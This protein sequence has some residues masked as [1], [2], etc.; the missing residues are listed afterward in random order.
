MVGSVVKNWRRSY[1]ARQFSIIAVL[2]LL[3]LYSIGRIVD[4]SLLD[5]RQDYS[6]YI[7][8]ALAIV[9]A[10]VGGAFVIFG[11]GETVRPMRLF[12]PYYIFAVVPFFV[13]LT[14]REYFGVF[15]VNAIL[16]HLSAGVEGSKLDPALLQAIVLFS[17]A[18]F[19]ICAAIHVLGTHALKLQ[20][21]VNALAVPMLLLNPLTIEGVYSLTFPATDLSP[22]G[23]FFTPVQ[24][25]R[26]A[27]SS[28]P[29]IIHIY[30]ESTEATFA[31][32]NETR[33]AMEPLERLRGRGF[34]AT[35]I[36]Q[37]EATAWTVAGQ[38]ASQCGVPLI[39]PWA[40]RVGAAPRAA[41][42]MP[43]AT[44][45]SD[46]LARDGYRTEFLKGFSL[47]FAGTDAFLRSHNYKSGVGLSDHPGFSGPVSDWGAY[48]DETFDFAFKRI[49]QL[50]DAEAP[51]YFSVL[52]NGA[53]FPGG[54]LSP[55]C[56]DNAKESPAFPSFAGAIGCTNR[57]TEQFVRKLEQAKLLEN[58]IVIVQSD[59]LI[60]RNPLDAA[61]SE[62]RRS[63]F[64][65]AF[66]PG[67]PQMTTDQEASM[68]DVYPTILELIGYDIPENRAALGVSLLSGKPTLIEKLGAD[69]LDH[70]IGGGTDLAKALWPEKTTAAA[71]GSD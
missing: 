35:S 56:A 49:G 32:L 8:C 27:D 4:N 59:H 34:S 14:V 37:V 22:G 29:N 20:T 33:I 58:T 15:D 57:L 25:D 11:Q 67:V 66:G 51:F 64:F 48:D 53:H 44:C 13:W 3:F 55:A 42:F 30:L 46:L 52:T 19:C 16:Y 23:P 61:L 6:I 9:T 70:S 63:N 47:S 41:H 50:H 38:V 18:C 5:G 26:T 43:G 31:K 1:A 12:R 71:R 28:R 69:E 68:L 24:A 45:L 36:A 65:T 54:L 62:H 7:K 21:I 10:L 39:F 17:V 2:C 60:M 40:Q